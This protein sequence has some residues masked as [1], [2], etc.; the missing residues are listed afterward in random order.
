MDFSFTPDEEQLRL[1]VQAFIG[2]HL[3]EAL[4]QE[5]RVESR[6]SGRFCQFS[7]RFAGHSES[8]RYWRCGL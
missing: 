3:T 1:D 7:R 5:L 2:E 4:T 6:G 8:R